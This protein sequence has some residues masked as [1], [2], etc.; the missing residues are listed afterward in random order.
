MEANE[1]AMS[2]CFREVLRTNSDVICELAYERREVSSNLGKLKKAIEADPQ[3]VSE[4]HKDLWRKQAK[5]MQEYVNV[6][7][8]RIKDLIDSDT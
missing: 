5:A 8:E 7:S 3:S 4:H 6:L 1:N 2:K